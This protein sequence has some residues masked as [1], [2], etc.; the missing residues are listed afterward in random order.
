MSFS[1]S[2]ILLITPSILYCWALYL[3]CMSM[4]VDRESEIIVSFIDWEERRFPVGKNEN[5]HIS[6]LYL[7]APFVY[8]L[9]VAHHN[10]SHFFK[11]FPFGLPFLPECLVPMIVSDKWN[12]MILH[13]CLHVLCIQGNRLHPVGWLTQS[14][15]VLSHAAG[16]C[17]LY[18]HVLPI[19]MRELFSWSHFFILLILYCCYQERLLLYGSSIWHGWWVNVSAKSEVHDLVNIS[20]CQQY[21]NGRSKGVS[22]IRLIHLRSQ[23]LAGWHWWS[24]FEWTCKIMM[25]APCATRVNINC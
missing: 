16:F 22:C 25:I 12:G 1:V 10:L 17:F 24:L 20:C 7:P 11:V 4:N 13:C 2:N 19:H 6:S 23:V 8:A 3:V 21:A 5:L 14:V 9:R 18:W 15:C